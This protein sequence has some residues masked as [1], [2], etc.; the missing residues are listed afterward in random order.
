HVLIEDKEKLQQV[1][2]KLRCIELAQEC[3][4]PVPDTYLITSKEELEKVADLTD[5]NVVVKYADSCSSQGLVIY[6]KGKDHF[7][8]EYTNNFDFNSSSGN[9]PFAQ[10]LIDCDLIDTTA[11]GINGETIAVL[12]QQ[13]LLCD[14]VTGGGGIVNITNDVPE[15]MEHTK[16]LIRKLNWTGHIELDWVRDKHTGKYYLL[17][18]NPK[19]WGTTQLTI[20]A[21][22]DYP[23][24][25]VSHVNGKTITV[26]GEYKKGLMYR[27]LD[28]EIK[29]IL[30]ECKSF[31][32]FYKESKKFILRFFYRKC[33]YNVWWSDIK[34]FIYAFLKA[35][36]LVFMIRIMNV[37]LRRFKV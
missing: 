8:K 11:F 2:D 32:Q 9:V 1:H 10:K 13:R 20:S 37:N 30:T 22:Y 5:G 23:Y 3:N 28:Q 16:K 4:I 31:G 27:W 15:I 34:P 24:W 25:F 14:W 35:I 7:L 36:F 6:Q 12:S 26:P 29:V 18:I 19:I 33:K 17:E 21:G